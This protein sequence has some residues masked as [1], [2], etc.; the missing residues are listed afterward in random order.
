M[1]AFITADELLADPEPL[2]IATRRK[3]KT[4]KMVDATVRL[5]LRRPTDIE[6]DMSAQAANGARRALRKLL[7]DESTDEHKLLLRGPLEDA[8]EDSLRTLWV[9]G[10]LLERAA[11]MQLD[12]LEDREVVPEPEGPI[13][14]SAANDAHDEAVE[15]AEGDRKT[16]LLEAIQSA[17]RELTEEAAAIPSNAIMQNAMP[18]HTETIAQKTWNDVYTANI[19]VRGTFSDKDYRKPYF[20]TVSQVEKLR[21]QR[22]SVYRQIAETHAALLLELEPTLGN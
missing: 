17:H 6:K 9:S 7:L 14:T 15:A 13:V 18:A 22:P 1:T 20:K 3:D 12:S 11:Q 21:S 5:Y 4:G 19:I 16:R 2:D 10:R 8:D